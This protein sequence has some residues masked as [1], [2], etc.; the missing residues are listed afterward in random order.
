MSLPLL[1]MA[2]GGSNVQ[3]EMTLDGGFIN[4]ATSQNIRFNSDG[5]VTGFNGFLMQTINE[6]WATASTTIDGSKYEIRATL[7]GE[8]GGG[9]GSG[10]LGSWEGLGSTRT[11]SVSATATAEIQW[12]IR[13]ASTGTVQDT[14]SF[15]IAAS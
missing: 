3:V 5:T 15:I 13:L 9:L 6:V 14:D 7:I 1:L 11:W 8:T 2:L 12:E 10:T 4:G